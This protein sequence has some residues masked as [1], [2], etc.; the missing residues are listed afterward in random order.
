MTIQPG[1]SL[2]GELVAGPHGEPGDE[3]RSGDLDLPTERAEG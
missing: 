1:I 2:L 3:S